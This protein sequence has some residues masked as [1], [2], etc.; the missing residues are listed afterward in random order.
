MPKT[1]MNGDDMKT[2]KKADSL[3]GL[4]ALI[5]LE[6]AEA[7]RDQYGRLAFMAA[8]R[9]IEGHVRS[10]FR[11]DDQTFQL[12]HLVVMLLSDTDRKGLSAR[13]QK[14]AY[15][16]NK[17]KLTWYG[18]DLPLCV[19][20]SMRPFKGADDFCQNLTDHL[21]ALFSS[22]KMKAAAFADQDWHGVCI[23]KN[24]LDTHNR[25]NT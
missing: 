18:Q 19:S 21:P 1:D 5:E 4:A 12:A 6:N 20:V 7:L 3:S 10:R 13:L 15:E 25:L 22:A 14:L 23:D 17:K 16:L 9:M 11:T 8:M 24:R 2:L